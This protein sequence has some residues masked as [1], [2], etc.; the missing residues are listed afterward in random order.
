MIKTFAILFILPLL[1]SLN[2]AVAQTVTTG[3]TDL[4]ANSD[5]P[6][7]ITSEELEILDNENKAIFKRDVIATQ[8]VTTLQTKV[9]TVFYLDDVEQN[10]QRISK[11]EA[12]GGVLLTSRDQ[13]IS[14][15]NGIF[16]YENQYL[17]IDRR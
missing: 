15:D 3:F 5:E 6:I 2:N 8:G 7:E 13:Q 17:R 14:G 16:D 10:D 11:F 4:G 9:L 12:N 1:M